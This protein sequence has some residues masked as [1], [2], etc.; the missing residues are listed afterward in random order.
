MQK[1]QT[2]VEQRG[3][4]RLGIDGDRKR[5]REQEFPPSLYAGPWLDHPIMAYSPRLY[6]TDPDR[7]KVTK[8]KG[9]GVPRWDT[10]SNTAPKATMS[11]LLTFLLMSF[12]WE[13]RGIG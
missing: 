7:S 13:R 10:R 5:G 11:A 1:L 3:G 12:Y 4:V 6:R 2:L 9:L 8:I